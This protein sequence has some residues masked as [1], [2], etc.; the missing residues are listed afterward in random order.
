[1]SEEASLAIR[2]ADVNDAEA[3]ARLFRAVWRADLPYLPELHTPEEDLWFFR[4]RVF[5]ECEVWVAGAPDAF[6][7]FRRESADHGWVDHLYVRGTHQGRGLGT[8][9]LAQAMRTHAPL[10]LWA[11][12]KNAAAIRFYR[13]RGF[14]EIE[15][16]DGSRNEEREPDVLMEWRRA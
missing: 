11:F 10:R 1:M 14:C 4:H 16:T 3:I 6:I 5:V 13:A 7:A 12:Q 9:L 8:A 2:R 15:R